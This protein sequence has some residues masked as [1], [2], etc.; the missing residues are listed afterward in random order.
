MTQK[1]F[2]RYYFFRIKCI[3]FTY[4]LSL[5]SL[6]VQDRDGWTSN[7]PSFPPSSPGPPP[8]PARR[9]PHTDS[10]DTV[11]SGDMPR[12]LS[13]PPSPTHAPLPPPRPG[14][15]DNTRNTRPLSTVYNNTAP[16][17]SSDPTPTNRP[18]ITN[19]GTTYADLK[20]SPP[21]GPVPTP[22]R[23]TAYT[24]VRKHPK[25]HKSDSGITVPVQA[26]D[27]PALPPPGDPLD[28]PPLPPRELDH[29]APLPPPPVTDMNFDFSADTG[30]GDL[31]PWLQSESPYS[32]TP[33]SVPSNVSNDNDGYLRE[34]NG[35]PLYSNNAIS[36][37]GTFPELNDNDTCTYTGGSSAYED[38]SLILAA[39][40]RGK[41][42]GNA[43]PVMIHPGDSHSGYTSP[44]FDIRSNNDVGGERE[45]TLV[46]TPSSSPPANDG[47]QFPSELDIHPGSFD[48]REPRPSHVNCTNETGSQDVMGCSTHAD[49]Y[50]EPPLG[51][52]NF[53]PKPK[54]RESS[55][56]PPP[57]YNS[58]FAG[59]PPSTD[60]SLSVEPT[61]R[62][63]MTTT[64]TH[65]PNS[66]RNEPPLPP[67]NPHPR[68]NGQSGEPPLP[69]RNPT[70]VTTSPG[71]ALSGTPTTQRS[72][73]REHT[74]LEL[75]KLGY[76]RSEVVKALAIAQ[77]STELA[78]KILESFGSR[79]D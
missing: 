77:N 18:T 36:D 39:I 59:N 22:R 79:K 52:L 3:F 47:Y 64:P 41:Q 24:E 69:P 9:A 73:Q 14:H 75:V 19:T 33:V 46:D 21:A 60:R 42:M 15:H 71:P 54:P 23:N 16:P 56:T 61:P 8:P 26:Y 49:L 4:S 70:R 50:D 48:T 5:S 43:P 44:V 30:I 51:I 10:N 68:A 29:M 76:S 32:F 34:V 62:S 7:S 72:H 74:I 13:T 66:Q 78:K 65:V 57:G 67:R 25:V 37:L 27:I 31:P 35:N 11:D 55:N 53:P 38:S 40:N 28:L 2:I 17:T 45:V 12:S 20:F 1:I 63:R 58:I 6:P